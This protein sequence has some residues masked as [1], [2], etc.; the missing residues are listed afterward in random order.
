[1][2]SIFWDTETGI[3]KHRKIKRCKRW[4]KTTTKARDK[5][6]GNKKDIW[7]TKRRD[8]NKSKNKNTIKNQSREK[9]ISQHNRDRAKSRNIN[10]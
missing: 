3:R 8:N 6:R 1:M 10:F 5:E 2:T 7:I 4:K 9:R